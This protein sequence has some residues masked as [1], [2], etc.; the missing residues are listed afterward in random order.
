VLASQ[1]WFLFPIEP[2]PRGTICAGVRLVIIVAYYGR[3]WA[4]RSKMVA[5]MPA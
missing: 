1:L 2:Y 5:C 4:D 3:A